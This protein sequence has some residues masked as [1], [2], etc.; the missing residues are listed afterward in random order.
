[1][2]YLNLLTGIDLYMQIDSCY[3]DCSMHM[4]SLHI[5][6]CIHIDGQKSQKGLLANVVVLW[7]M[8]K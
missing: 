5:P 1:M 6:S 4:E 3:F 7:R 2:L 8:Q